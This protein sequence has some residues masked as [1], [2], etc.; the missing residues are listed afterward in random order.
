MLTNYW[1]EQY[2]KEVLADEIKD[3][4]LGVFAGQMFR[5]SMTEDISHEV[6]NYMRRHGKTNYKVYI[7]MAQDAS[8][9]GYELFIE[10]P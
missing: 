2:N 8:G 4:I 9:H 7:R 3:Y 6:G 1:I 10:I 5:P